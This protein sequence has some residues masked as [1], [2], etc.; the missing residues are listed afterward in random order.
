MI[1]NEV[2]TLPNG[3]EIP[4]MG[5]GTWEIADEKVAE[6]V[7]EAIKIGYRHIDTAQGYG[8]ER[9]VGEGIRNSNVSREE[10]FVTTK[11]EADIKEYDAAVRA[12]EGS[13]EKL[14]ID[15]I[16]LLIIHSPQPWADFRGENRY[17]KENLE[18]WR[19]LEE[20]YNAGKLR[21][22]GVSNFD[23]EDLDNLLENASIKP[24]LNQILA[25]ISN[26]PFNLIEHCQKNNVLVEA[27]SPIAHGEILNQEE[28]MAIADRYNVT[29]PQLCVRY[30]L[31]LD[32]LPFHNYVFVIT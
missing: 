31:E 13:L 19:A 11:L 29:V 8:N 27:Y 25:H 21:T 30:Y 10:L 4:K 12:I 26:T 32:L 6:A 24:M 14:D 15:Y 20:F 3:V 16:D 5:L 9:G 23:Q 22:I 17:F 18:V 2:F 28:I 1:L 7:K